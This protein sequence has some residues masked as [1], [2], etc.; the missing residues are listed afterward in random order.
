M[1]SKGEKLPIQKSDSWKM[2]NHISPKYDFLNHLLS[3]GLDILWR[4][5][6]TKFIVDRKSL[7]VLDVA[8]GTA[9]VLLSFFQ[10]NPYMHL[11]FGIDMADKMLEVGRKKVQEKGLEKHIK[12][13][14]ADANK[15][16]FDDDTFDMVS[17]AFGIRN[18]EDPLKVL[19]EMNRVLN[20]EGRAL[21]LEFSLPE[22]KWMRSLHLFYL[23]NVVPFL[24]G[25]FTGEQKAYKYLNQTIETFPYGKEFCKLLTQAGYVN[26]KANPLFF[27]IATI[28]QGDKL[29]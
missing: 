5:K 26:V 7:K 11:G 12:L 28:Y 4:K 23:R 8:T 24:G 14:S 29:R 20:K 18:M 9:D 27:G 6:M 17:I 19:R 10:H 25:L 22:N 16:P 3:F 2:F 1:N 15:I 13:Q 21:V